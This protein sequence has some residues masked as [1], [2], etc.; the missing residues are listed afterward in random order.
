M[1]M[2]NKIKVHTIIPKEKSQLTSMSSVA[3]KI[4]SIDNKISLKICKNISGFWKQ[5][6]PVTICMGKI[7]LLICKKNNLPSSSAHVWVCGCMY[8][9]R[10]VSVRVCISLSFL[11]RGY[12][13]RHNIY[14]N[15]YN[16]CSFVDLIALFII[17]YT[18]CTFIIL[19][20]SIYI[21]SVY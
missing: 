19:N 5:M 2:F 13:C 12:S 6:S 7:W 20:S 3:K 15:F 18:L 9:F 17:C 11:L 8:A 10:I 21:V 16:C 1:C 4:L 14:C